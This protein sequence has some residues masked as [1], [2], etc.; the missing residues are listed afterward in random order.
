MLV[1]GLALPL[2]AFAADDPELARH[3]AELERKVDSLTVLLR[4]VIEAD[5]KRDEA[6]QRALE[7]MGGER[8]EA[9][10]AKEPAPPPKP[11]EPLAEAERR[12]SGP[13]VGTITGFAKRTD[14]AESRAWVYVENVPG[15]MVNG[16][17]D[18][19]QI[20]KQFSPRFLLVQ[21]GT[22]VRFPNMDS[23]Y[24]NVFSHSPGN[25]F[26]L[27]QFR[28]GDPANGRVFASPG[29]VQIFCGIHSQMDAT[30]IVVPN[31]F[32]VRAEKDGSYALRGVPA[33]KRRIVA[34]G[35]NLET[36]SKW[37]NVEP[38]QEAE[39]TFELKPSV[40][41]PHLRPNGTPY[42]YGKE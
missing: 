2:R 16:T 17:V 15:R 33:G 13:Q 18:I 41:K 6:I 19:K 22:R 26:D 8:R 20:D 3:V 29:E 25:E 24:H 37:V 5:R 42:E 11:P 27:G 14:G 30:M 23:V 10:R 35:P 1:F 7:Q 21:K 9:P 38:A 40:Y 32:F 31:A 39:L 28:R 36:E 34:V 4:A 12:P